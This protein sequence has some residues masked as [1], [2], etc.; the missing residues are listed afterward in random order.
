ME[1]ENFLYIQC[2]L[3]SNDLTKCQLEICILF[4]NQYIEHIPYSS[5]S[6][7]A[8]LLLILLSNL[9]SMFSWMI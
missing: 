5:N 3:D 8:M 7:I 2:R 1:G 4:D 6:L 9:I